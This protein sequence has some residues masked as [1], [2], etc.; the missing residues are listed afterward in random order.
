MLKHRVP[1]GLLMIVG[2]VAV[3]FIDNRLDEIDI[4]GTWAQHLFLGR[5]YLP[6]GL[7]MLGCFLIIIALGARELCTIFRAEHI[8]ADPL[9]IWA[10]GTIGCVL[11][12]IIPYTLDSQSTIAIYASFMVVIFVLSLTR[13][14]WRGRT[15]GAVAVAAVTM[16]ALIYLGALPGFY[17]AIRRWHSAWIVAALIL[18][19][20]SCDIGAYF[21]GRLVGRHK[22]IAWLSP[23]KTWEGLLGGVVLAAGVSVLLAWLGNQYGVTGRW[24]TTGQERVFEPFTFPLWYAAIAGALVAVVG[25]IGD[26]T[27]SLFKRDAGMKDSGRSIPG[28][29]GLIDVVD[30]PILVAP[31]AYWL[32]AVAAALS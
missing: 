15:Q 11:V 31:L 27:A 7:L 3:F 24:T 5:S 22:L 2:L 30:S 8:E 13:Y 29:G 1:V 20:K 17:L 6:A 12:Y 16:F 4:S 26:L 18:I 28:F 25:Q 14:S 9:M 23:G 21:T 10:S 19:T 32:L